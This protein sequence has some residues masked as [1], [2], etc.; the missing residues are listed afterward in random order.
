MTIKYENKRPRIEITALID[1]MF[2]LVLFFVVFTTF[3]TYEA[4]INLQLP[5]AAT[6]ESALQGLM[7]ISISKE[8]DMYLSDRRMSEEQLLASVKTRLASNPQEVIV[9]RADESIPYSYV[10]K[11]MDIVQAGG[12]YNISLAV[13]KE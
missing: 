11:A 9:I 4:S 3:R 8:G 12:G 10:V 7:V 5:K 13:E 2:S 6:G 1:I